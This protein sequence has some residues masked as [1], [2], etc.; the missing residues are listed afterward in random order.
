[1]GF[2][3]LF[4]CPLKS[5]LFILQGLQSMQICQKYAVAV[6]AHLNNFEGIFPWNNW[7]SQKH[8]KWVVEG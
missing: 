5:S 4:G 3:I 1:M 7:S 6:V 2:G 8:A